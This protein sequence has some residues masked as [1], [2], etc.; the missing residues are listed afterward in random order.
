MAAMPLH[1]LEATAKRKLGQRS[2]PYSMPAYRPP[3]KY[4]IG[5]STG[6]CCKSDPFLVD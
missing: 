6:R 1:V 3:K 5:E 4:C 2:R